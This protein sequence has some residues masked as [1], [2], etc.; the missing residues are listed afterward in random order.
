M[1]ELLCLDFL[2]HMFNDLMYFFFPSSLFFYLFFSL[3][4]LLWDYLGNYRNRRTKV[5]ASRWFLL[6][7][8]LAQAVLAF[9]LTKYDQT[10]HRLRRAFDLQS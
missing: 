4:C 9:K 7:Y 1:S 10:F 5:A 8:S 3:A 2:W 6:Y